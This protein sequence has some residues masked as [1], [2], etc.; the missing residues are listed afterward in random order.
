MSDD[1]KKNWSYAVEKN[2][3]TLFSKILQMVSLF[4]N[5]IEIKEFRDSY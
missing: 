2:M 5:S 3:N 1:I 4:L